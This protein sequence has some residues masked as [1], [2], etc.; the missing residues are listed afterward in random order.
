MPHGFDFASPPF[1][2]LR[3]AERLRL[4]AAVDVEFFR[5][6][7]RVLRAGSLPDFYHVLIKGL[8]EERAGEV[9]VALHGPGDGFDSGILVHKAC[10]HDFLVREEAIC[11]LLPIEDLLELTANNAAFGLWFFQSLSQKLDS[12]GERQMPASLGTLAVRVRD[13]GVRPP[14]RLPASAS[15]AEAAIAMD[16]A[17]RRAVLVETGNASGIVTDV[18]LTRAVLRRGMAAETP[19]GR[20][21]HGEPVSV[22]SDDFLA[23]AAWL[24]AR[25]NIRHLLVRE[26]GAVVG[27]LD[28]GELLRSMAADSDAL[29][30]RIEQA[31]TVGELAGAAEAITGLVRQLAGSGTRP[32]ILAA[33]SSELHR[34]LVAR[35]FALLAP[36][37]LA[38]R[39]ALV[40]M[41]SEGRGELVL[42]TDQDNGMVLEDGPAPEGLD[43]FRERFAGAMVAVG[44][45]P[46]PGGVMVSNP[47]W[48]RP[49]AAWRHAFRR[50]AAVPDEAAL[51]G[52]AILVDASLAAGRADLADAAREALFAA[53]DGND[54]FHARFAAAIDLFEEPAGLM[55][56]FPGSRGSREEGLDIKRAGLFPLMHGVRALALERGLR[57]TGTAR[58]IRLLHEA[59]VLD[60]EAAAELVDAFWYLSGLRLEARLEKLRLHRPL[61]DLVSP[62]ALGKLERDL[63]KESLEAVR[64]LRVLV[65]HHFR[66]AWLG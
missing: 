30:G 20:I 10:R 56:L 65:R 25:R 9:P 62:G 2:R 15:L 63:L 22:E 41:G 57:E 26:E 13:A 23:E 27:L 54:A 37:G 46:C 52:T 5:E 1:D 6:G 58:R 4:E 24:M 33:L 32:R 60:R 29:H 59:G 28:A 39:A 34:R 8:V 3:P 38:A 17:G 64:R 7:A 53:L 43:A 12:L 45:P 40:V 19:L 61:D 51:M 21:A 48:T 55:S 47:F 18:D 49:L 44:F 31:A 35:L 36:P 11:W 50:W 42:R 66:L 16:E 14:L